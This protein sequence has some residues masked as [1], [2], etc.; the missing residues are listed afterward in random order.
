MNQDFMSTANSTGRDIDRN[1]KLTLTW[2]A[3][4]RG[5]KRDGRPFWPECMENTVLTTDRHSA[6]FS[7]K[8][9]DTRYASPS[10]ENLNYLIRLDKKQ[11]CIII[12]AT[13]VLL[14]KPCIGEL[15]SRGYSRYKPGQKP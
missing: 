9:K 3:K 4:G 5:A 10:A 15:E 13:G 2:I 12:A 11:E 1:P 8:V 6:Y 7:M 14:E